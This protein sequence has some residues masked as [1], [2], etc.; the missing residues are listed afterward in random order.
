MSK[1]YNYEYMG[2][3]RVDGWYKYVLKREDGKIV[4]I[5]R[6]RLSQLRREERLKG[7]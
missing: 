3:D 6:S 2:T 1:K 7:Y 4:K 5:G